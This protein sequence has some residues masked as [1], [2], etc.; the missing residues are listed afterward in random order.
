[1]TPLG[2][3]VASSDVVSM[4]VNCPDKQTK[5]P[6]Q[7]SKL[8]LLSETSS[9]L[10]PDHQVVPLM[11]SHGSSAVLPDRIQKSW[12]S[13]LSHMSQKWTLRGAPDAHP[14]EGRG[15]PSTALP[16]P[17]AASVSSSRAVLQSLCPPNLQACLEAPESFSWGHSLRCRKTEA[18]SLF[19]STPR[20]EVGTGGGIHSSLTSFYT[21][22]FCCFDL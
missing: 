9:L 7:V 12:A 4:E 20:G 8:T 13:P 3:W 1:M 16:R 21:G 15:T 6:Q 11:G 14:T 18:E 5:V 22:V 17:L 19:S 2:H 10:L